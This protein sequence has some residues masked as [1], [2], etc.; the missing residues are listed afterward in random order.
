MAVLIGWYSRRVFILSH[1]WS[2]ASR[3]WDGSRGSWG[4]SILALINASCPSPAHLTG[5]IDVLGKLR[6]LVVFVVVVTQ[7]GR[8]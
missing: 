2:P 1:G 3:G 4:D 7:I 5:S 6:V 8:I